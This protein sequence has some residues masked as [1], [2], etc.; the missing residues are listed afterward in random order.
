M[1]RAL[2]RLAAL[3]AAVF[4]IMVSVA[5][6]GGERVA[7]DKVLLSRLQE[8]VGSW[9]GVGQPRRGSTQGAWTETTDWAWKFADGRAS[10]VFESPKGKYYR[11]GTLLPGDIK[12]SFELV[13]RRSDE[14]GEDRF[15]GRVDDQD[16]LVLL[17]AEAGEGPTDGVARIT[18]HTVADGDRLLILY[19]KRA[20][21]DRH[22]RLAEVGYTRV[23][24]SFAKGSGEPECVVTGGV[25]TIAVEH[26]GKKY[27]VCCTG[28][29]DLFNDDPEAVLADYRERKAAEREKAGE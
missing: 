6:A 4:C 2:A 15:T 9:R 25:G 14:S 3:W 1:G 19:E 22:V 24:I 29:R 18:I 21:A 23:G 27:Y 12:N 28:C 8:F 17:A 5:A 13:A 10:L 26:R 7:A 11:S 20:G 16:Q